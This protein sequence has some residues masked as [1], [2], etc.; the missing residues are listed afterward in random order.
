MDLM[1]SAM[2]SERGKNQ[3]NTDNKEMNSFYQ[4]MCKSIDGYVFIC[5]QSTAESGYKVTLSEEFIQEFQLPEGYETQYFEIWSNKIH[6]EDKE[7]YHSN[8]QALVENKTK[9]LCMQYR[10]LNRNQKWTWIES[11][12]YLSGSEEN[13]PKLLAGVIRDMGRQ[14]QLDHTTGIMNKYAFREHAKQTMQEQIPFGVL[15]LNIDD[16]HHINELYDQT[17]GDNVLRTI[18]MYIQSRIE[19]NA[20]VYRLDGDEFA[21]LITNPKEEEAEE[22]YQRIA[23]HY[24]SQKE[25]QGKRYYC[26]FSGTYY[27]Y[28]D[29]K[30]YDDFIKSLKVGMTVVKRQGKNHLV[31]FRPEFL[32]YKERELELIELLRN[33]IEQDFEGFEL[34]FQPQ[35]Y[36]DTKVLKGAEAL[37]RWKCEKYGR[38]SPVEFVPLLEKTDMIQIVGKWVFRQAV[39][40]CRRWVCI[41]PQFSMS[42]NV[43]YLQLFDPKFVD[44]M[45]NCVEKAGISYQN[46]IVEITESKFISDKE[47][48]KRVFDSVRALGMKIAMDDFGTGYSSLGLLK[49]APADIVKIDKIFVRNIKENSFDS[50]FIRVVVELCHKVGIKVCL[51]G[52]EEDEE[53]NVV[54]EMDLDFIQGYLY[55]RPE[56]AERFYQMYL[57]K[58]QA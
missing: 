17:F 30:S 29:N 28:S 36:A 33:S 25:L 42:I 13:A 51:E 24:G 57:S 44:F 47:L 9:M 43:S 12:A 37:L 45:K 11:R 15:L 23:H 22:L 46:I 26:T 55:G 39:E 34:N 21:I 5:E 32:Q 16:F 1:D 18:G 53:M 8:L 31:R 48:L 41:Y 6:E 35:V 7:K 19:G 52:V 54:S 50:S 58:E 38:V 4:A 3:M 10:V 2:D 27:K 20:T 56:E 40:M 14:N 49:E